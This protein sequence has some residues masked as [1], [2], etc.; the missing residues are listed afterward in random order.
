MLK[1]HILS[2]CSHC[3]GEA[4]QPI[5]EAEDCQGR[6]YIQHAPCPFCE[7]SG[8]EPQWVNIEDFAKLLHQA[9]CPHE[10]TSMHGNIRFI[11]GDVWD[12]LTEVCDDCGVNLDKS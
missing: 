9:E 7:G 5:G 1:V 4:Y 12:D 10:H 3:N 2:I 8:Y 11:A 6:K